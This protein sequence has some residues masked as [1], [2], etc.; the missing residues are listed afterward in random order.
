MLFRASRL[1]ILGRCPYYHD[2]MHTL[3]LF[4]E[5]ALGFRSGDVSNVLNRRVNLASCCHLVSRPDR[6]C[7]CQM[8]SLAS[9]YPLSLLS[10]TPKFD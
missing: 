7:Q 3:P 4:F 5:G 10:L 9:G 8:L 6:H 2:R 1:V